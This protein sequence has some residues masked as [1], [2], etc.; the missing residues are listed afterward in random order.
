MWRAGLT[1]HARIARGET[2]EK[3]IDQKQQQKQQIEE[4][5]KEIVD[6]LDDTVNMINQAEDA[7]NATNAQLARQN[8]QLRGAMN[9]LDDMDDDMDRADDKLYIM[10]TC[11]CITM[12]CP[13]LMKKPTAGRSKERKGASEVMRANNVV[14]TAQPRGERLDED[15]DDIDDEERQNRKEKNRLDDISNGLDRLKDIAAQ[16]G[17][18]V[19][20]T[21]ALAKAMDSKIDEERARI[22]SANDRALGLLGEKPSGSDKGPVAQE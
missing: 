2:E 20:E 9:T 21:G 8:E 12:C 16:Q 22:K 11:C 19:K 13:C 6:D 3:E 10:E 7:G 15:A 14:R 5:K 1:S 17:E 4:K 18:N